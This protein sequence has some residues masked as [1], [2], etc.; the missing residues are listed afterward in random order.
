MGI[1]HAIEK[2]TYEQNIINNANLQCND[3][4][5]I[6]LPEMSCQLI[7]RLFKLKKSHRNIADSEKN[8]LITFFH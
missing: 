4:I 2:A 1:Y 7:E 5:I 8:I 3:G 6:K